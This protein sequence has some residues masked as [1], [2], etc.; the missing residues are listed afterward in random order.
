MSTYN[1]RAKCTCKMH[2]RDERLKCTRKAHASV[3]SLRE[4][5]LSNGIWLLGVLME[6]RSI[7]SPK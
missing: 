1:A 2:V 4:R 5:L 6:N 7:A 3:V